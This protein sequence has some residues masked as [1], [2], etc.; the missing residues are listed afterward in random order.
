MT[1]SPPLRRRNDSSRYFGSMKPAV[2]VDPD[3]VRPRNKAGWPD[4]HAAGHSAEVAQITLGCCFVPIEFQPG[5]GKVTLRH[6]AVVYL[7]RPDTVDGCLPRSGE[8][9]FW[10]SA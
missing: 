1:D 6:L 2:E 5:I 7:P 4:W 9:R 3:T 10:A 8:S